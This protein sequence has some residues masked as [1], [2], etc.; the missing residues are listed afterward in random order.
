[1]I[2]LNMELKKDAPT[3]QLTLLDGGSFTTAE[4]SKLHAGADSSPVRLY[5]W[6]FYLYHPGTGRH[7]LWD[8]GISSVRGI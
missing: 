7:V 4:M 8:V 6:C 2:N 5:D 3:V 1:M